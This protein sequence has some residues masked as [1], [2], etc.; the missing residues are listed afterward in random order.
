[1]REEDNKMTRSIKARLIIPMTLVIALVMAAVPAWACTSIPV[2]KGASVDGSVMTTHTDDC[3]YCDPR[4]IYYP[5]ADHPEGSMRKV[6]SIGTFRSPEEA[7]FVPP[8]EQGEIPQVS[9]T[10]AYFFG[11]YG[12][13]NEKQLAMG[14][15]TIGNRR[16]LSNPTAMFDIGE[17]SRIGLE[18]CTTARE[19]IALM[20]SLAEEY[21][22]R[23]SGECLTVADKNEVWLFEILGSTPLYQSA[24]WAAQRVPDD[25]VSV[26]ANRSRIG[27]IDLNNPDYFM[28]SKNVFDI[29]TE[30]GWWDPA[31][32]KPFVFYEAYAPK[33]NV[34]NSRREWRVLSIM[35]PSLNLDPWAQRY[36]FSVKPEIEVSVNTLNQIQRDHY[37]GTEFDLTKGLAAG[38]FG[39][40]D[41]WATPGSAGGAWERAISIFRAAYS[42]TAQLSN[43]LTDEVG[44]IL[45]FGSG[46]GQGTVYVPIYGSI[47]RVPSSYAIGSTVEFDPNAAWWVFD[48]VANWANL[49][50]SYMIVDI[51]AKQAE[52]ENRQFAMQPAI[53]SAAMNLMKTDPKLAREFLTQYTCSNADGVVDEYWEF[54]KWLI[55]KYNDGYNNVPKVG[56]SV[57][58][59]AGWL[60][61][62]GFGPLPAPS[63]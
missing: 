41:R 53:E 38:P 30:N 2:G 58:Y 55:V 17:L 44:G 12:M 27:E 32:G 42:W 10:Y 9:H 49:K 7:S 16:E 33:N 48:F 57:G 19:A 23:D 6:Y 31:S 40:P 63:K 39:S 8:V 62:V 25:H 51:K 28:A 24:V 56:A 29:A 47:T 35:A 34:Y 21:G 37:E 61:A 11:S 50:Y 36:P 43:G 13:I 18:R 15:T 4:I 52:I 20:G 54:A 60:K 45:G 1:M 22:Y 3:G 26:S 46:C 5:A 59:P 14:E